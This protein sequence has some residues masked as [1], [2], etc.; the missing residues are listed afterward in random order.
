MKQ[1]STNTSP[2]VHAANIISA[3][4]LALVPFHAFLTVWGSSLFG[5][6]TALRL[7]NAVLLALLT[8][9]GV[10][11]LVRD[12]PTRHWLASNRIAHII[13]V[14]TALTLFIGAISYLRGGVTATAL[15]YGILVNLRYLA[16]FL[17]TWGLARRNTW[18][19]AHWPKLLFY[20]AAVVCLFAI[21]QYTILPVDFLSH[22]GYS[23]YTIPPYET[24]NSNPEFIRVSSTLRGANPLGAYLIIILTGLATLVVTARAGVRR[25]LLISA[26]IAAGMALLV[27]F[28]RS[29]WL[30]TALAIGVVVFGLLKHRLAR[31]KFWLISLGIVVATA[32]CFTAFQHNRAVQN[33]VFHTD[34]T[35]TIDI[36]SN[37]ARTSHLRAGLDDIRRHPLGGGS[38]SAG[39]ASYHNAQP[40]IAENYFIQIA[41]EV[42]W[43][44]LGLYLAI[45]IAVAQ[46]LWRLRYSSPLALV[47]FASLVGI[48]LAA[49]L[50]HVWTDEALS[51][52]WWGLAGV[53]LGT[54]EVAKPKSKPRKQR[55]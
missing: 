27:S 22:F 5:H 1:T 30:G 33:A 2:S 55:Q 17:L 16:F 24:I 26:S 37:E 8:A 6:Y 13:F 4:I 50:S 47:C 43:I 21:V 48:S 40:K 7:W 23:Q 53:A 12:S 29:A 52:I 15:A 11:W 20:P 49:L 19:Y 25:A 54:A 45:L 10:W 34:D 28:S 51:F 35:S 32:V 46:R 3:T 44:G 42:G 36:S 31:R 41:Q 18:L 9:I 14:Y 38:G 39:F